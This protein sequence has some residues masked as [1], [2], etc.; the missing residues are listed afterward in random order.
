MLIRP[1]KQHKVLYKVK[2]QDNLLERKLV[3]I[4]IR[5][6]SHFLLFDSEIPE[7]KVSGNK[8]GNK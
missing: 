1:I 3:A 8:S 2:R 7:E 4:F 6:Q 5:T